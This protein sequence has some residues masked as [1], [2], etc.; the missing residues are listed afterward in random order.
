MTRSIFYTCCGVSLKQTVESHSE[1]HSKLHMKRR[2]NNYAL[3]KRNKD[4]SIPKPPLPSSYVDYTV[5]V[6]KNK[7]SWIEKHMKRIRR[8]QKRHD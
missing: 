4:G 1:I 7:I 2:K 8:H 3:G 5:T 6:K